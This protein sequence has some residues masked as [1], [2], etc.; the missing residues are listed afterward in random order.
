MARL[1]HPITGALYRTLEDGTI[2][3][4]SNGRRGVFRHDGVHLSGDL[5]IADPHM[6][7]W[8]GGPQLPEGQNKRRNRG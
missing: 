7:L 8:L 6:L 3:V 4:D 5:R 1:K 2:E